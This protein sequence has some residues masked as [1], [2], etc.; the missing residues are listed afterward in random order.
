MRII[1]PL[2]LKRI[3]HTLAG[4]CLYAVAYATGMRLHLRQQIIS[5]LL[6]VQ[7]SQRNA[8]IKSQ[9]TESGTRHTSRWKATCEKVLKTLDAV[10]SLHDI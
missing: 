5:I 10:G 3:I 2:Q 8:V 1:F 4:S 9:K 7:Y 6:D